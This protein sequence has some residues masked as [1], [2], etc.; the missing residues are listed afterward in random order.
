MIY[1]IASL[2]LS[3]N[4]SF[5]KNNLIHYNKEEINK[6]ISNNINVFSI[7]YELLNNNNTFI[8]VKIKIKTINTI[9]HNIYFKAFLKSDD[10]LAEYSLKCYSE[11]LNCIICL[12]YTEAFFDKNKKYYFYYSRN[13]SSSSIVFNNKDIFEDNKR[14]SL[15]FHPDIIKN[16]ILYKDKK[17]FLVKIGNNMVSNGKLYVVRKSKKILNE[18]KNEFNKY[19]NLN[20]FILTGSFLS[21]TLKG[22]KEAIRRGYK[23]V[24]AD[25]LFTKDDI[26][27]ISHGAELNKVSNGEGNLFD[28][29]YEELEALDFGI[30]INKI[31]SGEKLLKFEDLLKLC[32]KNNIIIDLDLSYL[33]YAQ[34]YNN[35]IKYANLIIKYAEQY[36]MINS[37][38][39]NDKRLFILDLFKSIRKDLSFSIKGM[40]E[41]KSIKQIEN[42]YQDSKILIYNMGELT[43]GKKIN[44]EAV[45]YGLSLGKKIKAAKIDNINFANKVESWGV[46]FI[47]TNKLESFLMKNDKEESIIFNCFNS[48][49]NI[50]ISICS[51][52]K[53][54]NLL[55]NE[56]YNIFY[57]TNIYNINNDI[58][59]EPIGEFKYIDSYSYDLQYYDIKYFNF[60]EGIIKLNITNSVK[61]NKIITGLIGPAYDNV[62][63]CYQ[64][65]IKC[66]GTGN[67]ILE[68]NINKN[69]S[70]KILFKGK[71][72]FYH[73]DGYSYNPILH[74]EKL[75]RKTSEIFKIMIYIII[76]CIIIVNKKYS[77]KKIKL[78]I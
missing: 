60:E 20:N 67:N 77:R 58:V 66:H 19:I 30:K 43:E 76:I 31:Y 63:L 59:E 49:N 72:S 1:I 34:F 28:K 37:I 70:G 39:F 22:F 9:N 68:C 65:L 27:V 36:D 21:F 53:N 3:F 55:D 74:R 4:F 12:T 46:N 23:M 50:N 61:K 78:I 75:K 14:I 33:N 42:K 48:D 54:N 35:T 71:Y 44:K 6:Y 8:K 51:I 5:Q 18:N 62:P 56:I 38:I 2:N 40:N 45:K 15:V 13:K 52:D 73:L 17:Y 32:K 24:D 41:K 57:S 11:C 26:P 47:C 64:Y 7:S 29:T 16:Q 69:D 10:N 25:I